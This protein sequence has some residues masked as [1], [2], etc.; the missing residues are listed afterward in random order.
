ML[1]QF[2]AALRLYDRALDIT[3][4]D[5]DTM[6]AK[7][8]I[9]QAQGN[10]QEAAR[11]LSEINWE[12][13]NANTLA[14]KVNQLRLERN[15]GEAVR[16]L[17]TRVAQFR[18]ASQSDKGFFQAGLALHQRLGGDLPGA[19]VT[20]EEARRIL[21]QLCKDQPDNFNFRM[22]LSRACAAMGEKDLALKTAERALM[23]YHQRRN[24][25]TVSWLEENLA[26]IQALLGE[27][28]GAISTLK[29]LLQAP[30][31]TGSYGP[32][33]ITPAL[34]RLD[35]FW[36]PLRSDPAFQKLCEEKPK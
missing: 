20:G 17:Q 34:L 28:S 12:T 9:Y 13:P 21:E 3:L 33:P 35:P 25:A 36:D 7:A 26:F 14:T 11:F 8:S 23:L 6:A 10:L 16:L 18:F 24:A 31:L 15:F 22:A 32:P 4:N 5:P 19:K 30:Y 1:R 29:Q 2:P 27:N